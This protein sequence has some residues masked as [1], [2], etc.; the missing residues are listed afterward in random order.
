MKTDFD[1]KFTASESYDERMDTNI[2]KYLRDQKH[3]FMNDIQVIWGYLQLGKSLEASRYIERMNNYMRFV[4]GIF[5]LN[6]PQLSLLL[7]NHVRDAAKRGISFDLESEVETIRDAFL[8]YE[9]D[10]LSIIGSLLDIAV[11]RVIAANRDMMLYMDIYDESDFL[12]IEFSSDAN[13]GHDCIGEPE[14]PDIRSVIWK[15]SGIG[16]CISSDILDG[17]D[18]ISACLE[19]I[20][21]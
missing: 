10:K 12:F 3:D 21:R 20:R 19:H 9:S 7:Y 18:K 1:S 14:L 11:N 15:A 5:N 8:E 6:Y 13:D 4:S 16:I 2:V 17:R